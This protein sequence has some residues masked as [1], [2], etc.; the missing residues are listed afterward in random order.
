MSQRPPADNKNSAPARTMDV[1]RK[2]ASRRKF[3]YDGKSTLS[4]DRLR[5]KDVC[6]CPARPWQTT[7]KTER[8][9]RK[10]LRGKMW[11]ANAALQLCA[12][13]RGVARGVP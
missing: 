6:R 3:E 5:A 11:P 9:L 2:F 12:D 4:V 1:F 13:R 8:Q 7:S 10:K